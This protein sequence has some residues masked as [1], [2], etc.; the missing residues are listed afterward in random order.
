MVACERR[1]QRAHRLQRR[2]QGR[3]VCTQQRQAA[4]H[5][6]CAKLLRQCGHT[7]C[8]LLAG[9]VD[10]SLEGGLVLGIA[11]SVA[12]CRSTLGNICGLAL[13]L[14]VVT[15]RAINGAF[16]RAVALYGWKAHLREG[17]QKQASQRECLLLHLTR[18][19][20]HLL[21]CCSRELSGLSARGRGEPCG[22][23][24]PLAVHQQ[25]ETMQHGL[26][27]DDAGGIRS[28]RSLQHAADDLLGACGGFRLRL[29]S[30]L[31]CRVRSR[32]T[33]DA[34]GEKH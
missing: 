17:C 21:E 33:R 34:T 30:G 29:P 9:R 28:P 6:L 26:I 19:L 3:L 10:Q 7:Y 16:S 31:R 13:A 23:T 24:A 14:G 12:F 8:A 4:S 20:V 22:G 5:T 18:V 2:R 32:R 15:A 25:Q 1:Q 11:R 27:G